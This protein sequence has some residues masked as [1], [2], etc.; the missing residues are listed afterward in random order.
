MLKKI[1][2]SFCLLRWAASIGNLTFNNCP[3]NFSV[4]N[5][6]STLALANHNL[7]VSLYSNVFSS[8]LQVNVTNSL[9]QGNLYPMI[10]T[11]TSTSFL[12][13]YIMVGSVF[14]LL[15]CVTVCCC[16]FERRCP[17]CRSWRRNY[18]KDPYSGCERRVTMF[19]TVF[20]ATGVVVA[21]IVVFSSFSLL[22]QDLAL[23][24]CSLYYALDV[25]TS[26][27]Q[28]AN[29]GGFGQVQSQ[30]SSITSLLNSTA[31]AVS[32]QLAGNSWITSGY[33]DM[34]N[35]N[36]DLWNN[37]QSSRVLSPDPVGTQAAMGAGTSLPTVVPR[38][39]LSGLGPN[40]TA[41][42]MVTDIDSGLRNTQKVIGG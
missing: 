22:R 27:N 41:G 13:P 16:T 1:I 17:P 12:L 30:V 25:A 11:F 33:T 7:A 32:S 2:I 4:A 19:F 36:L 8:E 42:A 29:W 26:G 24:K 28:A 23:F 6:N 38:F 5:F 3:S 18:L 10:K 39:V 21:T 34:Q 37:Y 14:G 15:Y 31:S 35:M 20:F 9:V 40:G